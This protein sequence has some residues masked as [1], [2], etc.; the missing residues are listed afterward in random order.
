MDAKPGRLDS[1]TNDFYNFGQQIG[2]FFQTQ[3]YLKFHI[4]LSRYPKFM[5]FQ[6]LHYL[7]L[8]L[9]TKNH[10][11]SNHKMALGVRVLGLEDKVGIHCFFTQ[12]LSI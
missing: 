6:D 8:K 11:L 7:I 5:S 10:G 3:K 4:F 12:T 1:N 2:H 9:L